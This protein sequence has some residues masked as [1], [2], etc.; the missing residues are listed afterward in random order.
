MDQDLPRV[1]KE[2]ISTLTLSL[3][4]CYVM[5]SVTG[6]YLEN[7]QENAHTRLL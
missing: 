5:I 1:K 2:M 3:D 7:S 6:E 4:R